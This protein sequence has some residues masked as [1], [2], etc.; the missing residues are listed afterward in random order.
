MPCVHGTNIFALEMLCQSMCAVG[1][2]SSRGCISLVGRNA[3]LC[4]RSRKTRTYPTSACN[5]H[6]TYWNV[7]Q[8]NNKPRFDSNV[9]G[10]SRKYDFCLNCGNTYTYIISTRDQLGMLAWICSQVS[11]VDHYMWCH[12]TLGRLAMDHYG[13]KFLTFSVYILCLVGILLHSS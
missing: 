13:N 12:W 8:L 3:W 1:P 10:C 4:S 9:W 11:G 6:S 7:Y 2:E 5:R